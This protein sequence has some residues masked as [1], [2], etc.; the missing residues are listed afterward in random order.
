MRRF[1]QLALELEQTVRTNRKV[2]ALSSYFQ[3]VDAHD[4]AWAVRLLT[5]QRPKKLGASQNLRKLVHEH[6]GLPDWLMEACR[7]AV[8]DSSETWALLFPSKSKT[9]E[10]SLAQTIKQ[11]VLPLGHLDESGQRA[12]ILEALDQ[13][14]ASEK[15]VY[16]KIIRGGFR[17][18]LIHI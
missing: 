11:Y 17:L 7:S 13:L 6:I 14:S 18:S 9:C 8:G 4:G 5:G 2:S 15:Q 1:V 3:E 10:L 12:C 16:F